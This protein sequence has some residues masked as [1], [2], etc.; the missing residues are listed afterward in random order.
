MT[1]SSFLRQFKIKKVFAEGSH[2]TIA[3][4]SEK[5]RCMRWVGA[6]IDFVEALALALRTRLLQGI[7][8]H[9]IMLAGVQRTRKRR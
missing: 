5:I 3:F 8:L 4:G 9:L 7:V 2:V 1:I 6:F